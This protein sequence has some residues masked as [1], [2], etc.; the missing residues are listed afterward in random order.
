MPRLA[1][2]PLSARRDLRRRRHQ[3][4]DLLGGRRA[5][6]AVPVRRR[7]DRDAASSCPKSTAYCWHGYLPDVGPG[8][9]TASGST[10]RGSRSGATGAT[11]PSCSLD[12]YA[13]A[14]E[15]EVR[16]N[17]AVF[18]LPRSAT[19]TARNDPDSAPVRAQRRRRQPVLRL[20][21]TTGRRARP[22][23]ETV[24]YEAHVKG[25]TMRHPGVAA[26]LRG[27]YAGLAHP[28]FIEH[29]QTLGVTAVEL[30]P[31][32][33]FVHDRTSSSAACATTGA[34]TRSATSRRTTSTLARPAR[35]AGAGVQ[36]DGAGPARRPA[37]R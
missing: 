36:A 11:R 3:L 32:H 20:G 23:H 26:E 34:T 33:Q 18:P 2:T 19:P 14:V 37:S 8:S 10:G 27:T 24:I 17:E 29:L 22:W 13:K 35:R 25:L 31:V 1:R 30:M 16:W 5:G 7:G 6:R 28:A 12:P 9:A 15:G 21:G 4:L